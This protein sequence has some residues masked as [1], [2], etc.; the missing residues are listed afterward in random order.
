M[1]QIIIKMVVLMD[2]CKFM[3]D[4]TLIIEEEE[5]DLKG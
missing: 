1:N 5:E 4:L 3:M 2:F